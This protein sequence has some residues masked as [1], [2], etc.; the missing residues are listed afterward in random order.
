MPESPHVA[1]TLGWA[2]YKLG[3]QDA[4]IQQFQQCIKLPPGSAACRYH[5]GMVYDA[6]G[7]RDEAMP[8]LRQALKAPEFAY[9]AERRRRR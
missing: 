9:K 3:K 7:N 2:Y 1:D 6:R 8:S 5:S 4:A